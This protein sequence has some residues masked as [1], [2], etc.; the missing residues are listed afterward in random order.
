MHRIRTQGDE[1]WREV[2][3]CRDE[4]PEQFFPVGEKGRAVRMQIEEAKF[5]C[6]RCDVREACAEYA[7]ENGIDHGIW[8]GL[9]SAE[10]RTIARQTRRIGRLAIG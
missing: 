8:G 10:R 9:T 1:D 2:A 4:E 3:R 5:F 6:R 7:I